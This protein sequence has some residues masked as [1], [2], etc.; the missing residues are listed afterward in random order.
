VLECDYS[1]RDVR[2]PEFVRAQMGDNPDPERVMSRVN[3]SSVGVQGS[4]CRKGDARDRRKV[5]RLMSRVV[6]GDDGWDR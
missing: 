5:G 2:Y 3:G 6:K 4:D 1:L